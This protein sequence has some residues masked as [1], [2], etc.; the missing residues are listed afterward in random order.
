VVVPAVDDGDAH[1]GT[2]EAPRGLEA[3]EA[4]PDDH[5]LRTLGGARAH[6]REA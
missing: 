1:G 6:G 3:S 5:D 4:S 2:P